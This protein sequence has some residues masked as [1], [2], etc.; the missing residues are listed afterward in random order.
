MAEPELKTLLKMP[1]QH[2]SSHM[3]LNCVTVTFHHQKVESSS[4]PLNVGPPVTRVQQ[5][6]DAG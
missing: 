5:Q 2:L 1:Q 6:N 4:P 3:V